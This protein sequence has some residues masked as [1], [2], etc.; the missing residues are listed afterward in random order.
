MEIIAIIWAL[1]A[2]ALGFNIR[3]EVKTLT[4]VMILITTPDVTHNYWSLPKPLSELQ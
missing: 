3:E 4:R 1:C 2:L